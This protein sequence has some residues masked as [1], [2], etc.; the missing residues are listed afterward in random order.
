VERIKDIPSRVLGFRRIFSP[1][2]RR[3]GLNNQEPDTLLVLAN[4]SPERTTVCIHPCESP[5]R[6]KEPLMSCLDKCSFARDSNDPC[7]ISLGG[8]DFILLRQA[9]IL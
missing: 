8:Y 1:E 5:E 7:E 9:N 4:F 2:D 3:P 6:E